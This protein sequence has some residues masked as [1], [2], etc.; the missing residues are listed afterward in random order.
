MN[1]IFL[2]TGNFSDDM[3]FDSKIRI[4][5]VN[6]HQKEGNIFIKLSLRLLPK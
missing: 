2:I 4:L 3:G 1:E 5:D 6:T